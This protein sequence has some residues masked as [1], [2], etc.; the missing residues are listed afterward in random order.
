MLAARSAPCVLTPHDGE[1]ARLAGAP[2]GPDRLAAAR[3]L[4]ART[5]AVVLL[6]GPVTVVAEPG[7]Q[8]RMVTTGDRRLATAGTGDVLAGVIVALLARGTA[9]FDA[10]AAGAWL[11]GRGGAAGPRWG[12]VASDLLDAL[13]LARAE[14]GR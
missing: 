11:H 3:S 9:A 5:G 10:A 7:G 12:L 14:V 8:V 6:K 13:R 2:P 1:A 4:A